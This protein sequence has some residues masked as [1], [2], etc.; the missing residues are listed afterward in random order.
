MPRVKN[1]VETK[2]LKISMTEEAHVYLRQL[3][4]LGVYGETP[5]GVAHGLVMRALQ[6]LL[7]NG[8]IKKS[9]PDKQ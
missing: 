7:K 3:V 6:D 1:A 5:T 2:V 9:T 4:E 8:T